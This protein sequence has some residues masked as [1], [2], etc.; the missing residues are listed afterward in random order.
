[1]DRQ[2]HEALLAKHPDV[3]SLLF[4]DESLVSVEIVSVD[5]PERPASAI[6]AL[7]R[8][9]RAEGRQ[10]IGSTG[11]VMAATTATKSSHGVSK[12]LR[13]FETL[14]G[15]DSLVV[16]RILLPWYPKLATATVLR[17]AALQGLRGVSEREEEPGRIVH[18]ARRED[19]PI[20]RELT[21][22]RGWSWPYYGSVDATC[23]WLSL[24][25]SLARMQHLQ[26]EQSVIRRDNKTV[27][28]GDCALDAIDWLVGR[29]KSTPTGLLESSPKFRGS[30]ENQVWKDSWDS[31]SH[32]DGLFA[33]AGTVASVEVQGLAYDALCDAIWLYRKLGLGECGRALPL[34]TLLEQARQLRRTVLQDFWCDTPDRGGFFALGCDRDDHGTVRQLAVRSSNM[35][36]L[37]RSRILDGGDEEVVHKRTSLVRALFGSDMVCAA[38]LRTLSASATRYR[39]SGYHNGTSWPWDTYTV[40]EGLQRNGYRSL[41][42][43]FRQRVWCVYKEHRG[44]PEF[45]MGNSGAVPEFS[46]R[47]VTV[48][49]ELGRQYQIEQPPQ[50]VQAW[51]VAP[52]LAIKRTRQ[53]QFYT[54]APSASALEAELLRN[55][56]EP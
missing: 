26:A 21:L 45:A 55:V 8:L 39:P 54:E 22:H 47:V 31:Y 29:L 4:S 13:L 16:A 11:P 49:N 35:G 9:V 19:D 27:S 3:K 24:L 42:D 40:A 38:G 12:N 52:I 20:A 23:L 6:Q 15:R 50:Q 41:A 53:S 43:D 34:K 5:R 25:T 48:T 17:L 30:L 32:Q 33:R 37:L 56:T 18:E 2:R 44:F 10:E 28:L 7:R 1:M 51:T 36:H 46:S 14:F